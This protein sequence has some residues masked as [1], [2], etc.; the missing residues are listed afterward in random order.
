MR[1]N[2]EKKCFLSQEEIQNLVNDPEINEKSLPELITRLAGM[3]NQMNREIEKIKNK[4]LPIIN[5]HRSSINFLKQ[6]SHLKNLKEYNDFNS[7]KNKM[8]CQSSVF[9][10]ENANFSSVYVLNSV[11]IANYQSNNIKEINRNFRK[12]KK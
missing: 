3:E 12:F 9:D 10:E 11:K 1:N 4:Y 2:S 8:K 6:N 7:F 5:K